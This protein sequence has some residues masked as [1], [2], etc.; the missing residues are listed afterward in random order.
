LAAAGQPEDHPTRKALGRLEATAILTELTLSIVNER[1]LGRLGDVFSQ[2]RPRR[3]YRA[4]RQ[5]VGAGLALNVLGLR[6]FRTPV[7]HLASVMYLAGGLAF[8]FAWVEAGKAS[9]RDDE[10][11]ALMARDRATFEDRS[12]S[13]ERRVLS[14][15]RPPRATGSAVA[16]LRGWSR[17]VGRLSLAVERWQRRA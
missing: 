8:R 7:E 12:R 10:A 2:G 9:A 11:V 4:A 3:P 5:L 1:C 6:R 14:G 16:A 15:D 17:T 13:T